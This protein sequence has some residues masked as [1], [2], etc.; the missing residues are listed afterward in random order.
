MH[1][2]RDVL[3]VSEKGRRE[4]HHLAEKIDRRERTHA[5]EYSGQPVIRHVAVKCLIRPDLDAHTTMTA[6]AQALTL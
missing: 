4:R 1:D 5:A 3:L 6:T 2:Q